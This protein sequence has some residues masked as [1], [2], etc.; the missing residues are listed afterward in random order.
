M[1]ITPNDVVVCSEIVYDR[2]EKSGFHSLL[3]A[4]TGNEPVIVNESA[5]RVL[6]ECPRASKVSAIQSNVKAGYGNQDSRSIEQ[7]VLDCLDQMTAMGVVRKVLPDGPDFVHLTADDIRELLSFDWERFDKD[8]P[9]DNL[10]IRS[11]N[12]P[13]CTLSSP[14]V[15]R[16]ILFREDFDFFLLRSDIAS[17]VEGYVVTRATDEILS[18][19]VE[20]LCCNLSTGAV[21]KAIETVF[22]FYDRFA[23]VRR[24]VALCSSE[25]LDGLSRVGMPS[26]DLKICGVLEVPNNCGDGGSL[27]LV[28]AS[29][30]EKAS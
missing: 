7:D 21:G 2:E 28:V 26:S 30:L 16:S 20:V 29:R 27:F 4:V 5:Y 10:R 15:A 9:K 18:G 17:K 11:C 8:A 13:V 14:L 25:E 12:F 22:C 23:K 19:S 6:M 1:S 24:L 3:F